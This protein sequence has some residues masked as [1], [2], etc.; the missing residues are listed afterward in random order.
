MTE[1]NSDNGILRKILKCKMRRCGNSEARKRKTEKKNAIFL[2]LRNGRLNVRGIFI[3]ILFH[4]FKTR[5]E[6]QMLME[7]NGKILR[8]KLF[9]TLQSNDST[10]HEE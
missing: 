7:I 5:T 1:R 10:E 3:F 6:W 9:N 2:L 8:R 4:S